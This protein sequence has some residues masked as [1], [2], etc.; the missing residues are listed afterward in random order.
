MTQTKVE[1][2]GR[3]GSEHRGP[4]ALATGRVPK[5]PGVGRPAACRGH[6]GVD[7]RDEVQGGS[8]ISALNLVTKVTVR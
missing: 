5:T 1:P 3:W 8:L 2:S 6:R 4:E 7:Q